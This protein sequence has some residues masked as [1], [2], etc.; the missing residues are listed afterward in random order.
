[1]ELM[2]LMLVVPEAAAP[3]PAQPVAALPGQVSG[4]AEAGGDPGQAV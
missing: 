4:A 3:V 1:M 2:P